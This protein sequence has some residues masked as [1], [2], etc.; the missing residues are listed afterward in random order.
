M[1]CFNSQIVKTS[2]STRTLV[3]QESMLPHF[4]EFYRLDAWWGKEHMARKEGEDS[5]HVFSG[6][7]EYLPAKIKFTKHT[8]CLEQ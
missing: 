3:P 2:P 5:V 6:I 4:S 1:L 7:R 8:L